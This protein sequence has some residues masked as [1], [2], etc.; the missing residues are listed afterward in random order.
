MAIPVVAA[1]FHTKEEFDF[2]ELDP[3][4]EELP[5]LDVALV[6]ADLATLE[7]ESFD[8]VKDRCQGSLANYFV[9]VL[10][11]RTDEFDMRDKPKLQKLVSAYLRRAQVSSGDRDQVLFKHRGKIAQD[12]LEQIRQRIQDSTTVRYRITPRQVEWRAYWR[13]VPK[14]STEKHKDRVPDDEARGNIIGGYVRTVLTRNVFEGVQEKWLADILD[15]DSKV[16]RWVRPPTGQMPIAYKGGSYNPDFVVE[17]TG[18]R[19]VVLEVKARDE[20]HSE[21]VLAKAFAARDWC[22][23]MTKATETEWHY[24]LIPHDAVKKTRTLAGVLAE[25]VAIDPRAAIAG[26]PC[27]RTG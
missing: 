11:D 27:A 2:S 20:I 13:T 18:K 14:G 5:D 9:R 4:F 8:V 24:S 15:R 1:A 21:D 25:A 22:S 26:G 10:L 3:R 16:V 23:A 6:G 19:F 7:E 12:L 17:M